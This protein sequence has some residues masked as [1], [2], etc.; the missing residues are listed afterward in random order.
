M[1]QK[2]LLRK[3]ELHLSK[4]LRMAEQ[5]QAANSMQTVYER[6]YRVHSK[7]F[8]VQESDKRKLEKQMTNDKWMIVGHYWTSVK[9]VKLRATRCITRMPAL[10]W[11]WIV[12]T[13]ASGVILGKENRTIEFGQGYGDTWGRLRSYPHDEG[14]QGHVTWWG[15]AAYVHHV[16]WYQTTRKW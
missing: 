12:T 7:S 14:R 10:P 4:L 6:K 3:Q 1:L 2:K 9:A 15:G 11:V 13:V 16:P 5:W 8:G